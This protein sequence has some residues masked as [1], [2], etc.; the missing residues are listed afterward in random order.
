MAL[1]LAEVAVLAH[2]KEGG[3]GVGGGGRGG[4]ILRVGRGRRDELV[5]EAGRVSKRASKAACEHLACVS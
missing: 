2:G 1:R 4:E 3:C 5:Q